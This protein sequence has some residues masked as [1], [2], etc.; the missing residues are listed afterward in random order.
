MMIKKWTIAMLSSVFLILHLTSMPGYAAADISGSAAMINSGQII[1]GRV[2]VPLRAVS[3][4]LGA[5]LEWFQGDKLIKIKH[6]TSTIW[7]AANFRRVIVVAPP[8]LE[9]PDLPNRTYIDL[10]AATQVIKGTTYVPLRFVSQSL[11]AT[12]AWD[13][14]HKR[15]TVTL[16]GKGLVVSME[17]PSV[18]IS[19]KAQITGARLKLLSDQLNQASDISS[20]KD[21]TTYFQPYFTDKLIKFIVQNKGL[22]TAGTYGAPVTSPLYISKTSAT[23][24]QSVILGNGLTG[25]DQYVEDRVITLKFTNG[26]WKVDNVSKEFRV[27]ITGFS[28]YQPQ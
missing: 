12:V 28:D 23:F 1:N 11:G 21:V 16:G 18:D 24:S 2:L 20:I 4:N 22:D 13:Q 17:Q 26:V 7:L 5:N 8:T 6:G 25:E 14:Q 9:N 3:E 27:L 19:D 10:D 15:A